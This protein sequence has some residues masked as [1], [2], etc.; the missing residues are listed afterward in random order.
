[1]TATN[2]LL[3]LAG[4]DIDL[5]LLTADSI[6]LQATGDIVDANGGDLLNI[7]A[8]SLVIRA[9]GAIGA[10]NITAAPSVNVNA[11]DLDVAQFAASARD[12]VYVQQIDGA[13]DLTVTNIAAISGAISVRDVNFNSTRTTVD[14]QQS[15]DALAD[16][17]SVNGPIK[18]VVR[19]GALIVNE[20]G[21]RRLG[22]T[23][24][25]LG[26]H[27]FGSPRFGRRC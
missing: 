12:G 19:N 8:N 13:G 5:Y 17:E 14:V 6:S 1:M 15:R 20:G 24:D 26:R 9:G 11:I 10:A 4:D 25:W 3:A 22:C 18:I 23:R 7:Q 21:W 27:S 16:V 2:N